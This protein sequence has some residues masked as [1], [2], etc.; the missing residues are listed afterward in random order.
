MC[1]MLSVTRNC[2]N[3]TNLTFFIVSIPGSTVV[4]NWLFAHSVQ[5][6][7]ALRYAQASVS[8]C[9]FNKLQECIV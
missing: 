7:L 5:L 9:I 6:W 2:W 1:V 3:G 8:I 4:Q